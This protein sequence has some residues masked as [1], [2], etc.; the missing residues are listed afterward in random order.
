MAIDQTNYLDFGNILINE[1]AGDS[2]I[3]LMVCIVIITYLGMKFNVPYKITALFIIL[4]AGVTMIYDP[5]KIV[6]LIGVT[7]I[8]VLFGTALQIGVNRNR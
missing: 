2:I 6:L 7:V 3:F 1:I 5:L 8:G 4:A